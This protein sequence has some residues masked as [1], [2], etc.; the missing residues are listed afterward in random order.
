MVSGEGEKLSSAT[1]LL[2]EERL[3]ADETSGVAVLL[4]AERPVVRKEDV[5]R[6]AT[7]L[8]L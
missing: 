4:D 5:H 2:L 1:N 6:C 7:R 3:L 8:E